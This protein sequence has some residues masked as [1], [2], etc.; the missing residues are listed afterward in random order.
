MSPTP[1]ARRRRKALGIV[2]ALCIGALVIGGIW[3]GARLVML[4]EHTNELVKS[5]RETQKLIEDCTIPRDPPS[6][7]AKRSAKQ[8]AEAVSLISLQTQQQV[9]IALGCET[10]INDTIEEIEKCVRQETARIEQRR[11][12]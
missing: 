12:P 11:K 6:E 5:S 3:I 8:T 9:I 1:E 10:T 7:C 4:A 2:V